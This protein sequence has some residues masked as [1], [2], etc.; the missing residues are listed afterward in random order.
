M[1]QKEAHNERTGKT[2][3]INLMPIEIAE[4]G[5]KRV[6]Q[7]VDMQT[8]LLQNLQDANRQWLDRVQA[9]TNLVS[10]FAT[11]LTAA[12]S[13][14]EAMAVY[15]E[16]TSRRFEMMAEDGKHLLADTQKLMETGTRLLS[17]AS[18]INGSGGLGT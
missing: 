10:E 16:W 7:F 1:T 5:K 6:E 12:H 13:I 4:L 17:N 8:E 2:S 11:K 14:T 9:E 3:P 15:Q 18:A